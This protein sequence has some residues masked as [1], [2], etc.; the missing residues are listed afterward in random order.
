MECLSSSIVDSWGCTLHS[1]SPPRAIFFGWRSSAKTMFFSGLTG[2]W[3]TCLSKSAV[4]LAI[5]NS[6][7]C[8]PLKPVGIDVRN[9]RRYK[10]NVTLVW[11]TNI[12]LIVDRQH[13]FGTCKFGKML[14][15]YS[16][17]G[18]IGLF[19]SHYVALAFLR[20]YYPAAGSF[21]SRVSSSLAPF[22]T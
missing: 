13:H 16:M 7:R 2:N 4:P 8:A 22:G 6:L 17:T 9:C 15:S 14:S 18:E 12:R 21:L 11:A 20:V 3:W 5:N 10:W 19:G 1:G